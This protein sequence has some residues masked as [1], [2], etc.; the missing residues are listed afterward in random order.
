ML[1]F[2]CWADEESSHAERKVSVSSSFLF[3]YDGRHLFVQ[4][5]AG[6]SSSDVAEV[7]SPTVRRNRD[8]SAVAF[9]LYTLYFVL[10]YFVSRMIRIMKRV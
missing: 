6:L 3:L 10:L 8:G 2:L 5:I 9:V 4:K 7:L 1:L